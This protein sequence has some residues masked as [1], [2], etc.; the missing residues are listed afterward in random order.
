MRGLKHLINI[1]LC[2]SL[3]VAPHVGAW[4]ETIRLAEANADK[5]VAPHV[6]AWIETLKL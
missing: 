4:I 1:T 6:G 3:L 5:A 2:T